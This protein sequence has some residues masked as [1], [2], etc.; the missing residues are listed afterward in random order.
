MTTITKRKDILEFLTE[1]EI[2]PKEILKYKVNTKNVNQNDYINV[3]LYSM[4]ESYLLSEDY[5]FKN[6]RKDLY[7]VRKNVKYKFN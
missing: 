2:N 1:V 5:T 6:F 4:L 3:T 7:I